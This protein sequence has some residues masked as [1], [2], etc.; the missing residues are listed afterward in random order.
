M[1]VDRLTEPIMGTPLMQG[2]GTTTTGEKNTGGGT[3]KKGP[4][5]ANGDGGGQHHST[6]APGAPVPSSFHELTR[7]I[8]AY[9]VLRGEGTLPSYLSL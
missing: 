9:S 2:N 7:A 6:K 5:G 4:K 1:I 8:S 3:L